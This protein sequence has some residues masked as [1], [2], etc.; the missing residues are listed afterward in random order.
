MFFCKLF[1]KFFVIKNGRIINKFIENI[2]FKFFIV[3]ILCLVY[4]NAGSIFGSNDKEVEEVKSRLDSVESEVIAL[5]YRIDSLS[6][7]LKQTVAVLMA[8]K[9]LEGYGDL[10]KGQD[11]DES[12]REFLSL[13]KKKDYSSQLD[14]ITNRLDSLEKENRRLNRRIGKLKQKD[15]LEKK[16][17]KKKSEDLIKAEQKNTVEVESSEG[18]SDE[19]SLS[20]ISEDSYSINKIYDKALNLHREGKHQKSII[21][22]KKILESEVNTDLNDNAQFWIADCYYELEE[23]RKAISE[24]NKVVENYSDT[25]KEDDVLYNLGKCYEAIGENDKAKKY[26]QELIENYPDSEFFNLAIKRVKKL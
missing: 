26:L 1:G 21:K 24:F 19:T 22:F 8:I 17:S 15:T 20:D 7:Q 11:L 25:N 5:N 6:Q 4:L 10:D 23:Y 3:L 18:D 9:Q 14:S 16:V 12:Q 13:F 2:T